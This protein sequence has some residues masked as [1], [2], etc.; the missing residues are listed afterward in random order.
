MKDYQKRVVEEKAA[1]DE[2]L[3]ELTEFIGDGTS[4]AWL[5]VCPLEKELLC[6]QHSIML[7]YSDVLASRVEFYEWLDKHE[8]LVAERFG[9][10]E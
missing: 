4:G 9:S 10:K 3:W 5:A 2:K 1:L 6:A 7:Q 8:A